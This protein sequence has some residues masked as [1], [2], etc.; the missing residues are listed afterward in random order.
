MKS[1]PDDDSVRN[2]TEACTEFLNFGMTRKKNDQI[3]I[4]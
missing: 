4:L 2:L 3:N 1:Y